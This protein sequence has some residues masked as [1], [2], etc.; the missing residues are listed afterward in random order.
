MIVRCH[1]V[2]AIAP[3]DVEPYD[4]ETTLPDYAAR[5]RRTLGQALRNARLLC[6]GAGV[7]SFRV[8]ADRIVAFPTRTAGWHAIVLTV[9]S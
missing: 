3:R 6:M 5:D 7:K 9:V 2:H 4:R 8:E 1:Y